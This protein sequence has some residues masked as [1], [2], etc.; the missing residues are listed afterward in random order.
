MIDYIVD[1]TVLYI[2]DRAYA[3][4]LSVLKN[5]DG[6]KQYRSGRHKE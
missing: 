4:R 5:N 6:R 2:L 3:Q 1:C